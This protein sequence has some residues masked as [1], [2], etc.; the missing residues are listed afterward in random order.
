ML[1]K[2]NYVKATQSSCAKID[3]TNVYELIK[4]LVLF[5]IAVIRYTLTILMFA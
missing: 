1:Y 3:N 4:Y 5:I 2:S